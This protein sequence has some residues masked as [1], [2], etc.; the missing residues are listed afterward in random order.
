MKVLVIEP[1]FVHFGG[2][3]RSRPMCA[4]LSRKNIK[5]DLLVSSNSNFR[6]LIRRKKINENFRQYELPRINIHP[7]L[8]GRIL[9]GMIALWFGIFGRYDIIFARVPTQLESNIPAFFLRLLGKKVVLDWDDYWMGSPIFNGHNLIKK[10]IRF[11][12]TKS[13]KFF[14][15]MVVISDFLENKAKELGA[16]KIL[17]LINGVVVD[18]FKQRDPAESFEKL[19]LDKSKKYLLS[20]G[21][22]YSR[23]RTSLLFKAFEKMLRLDKE[24]RL[25]CNFDLAKKI[26]EQNLERK[27][28]EECLEN[29]IGM[30]YLSHKDL[31]YCL[32]IA[33][34][35][36]FLQGE[37][38]DELA[39]YP[40][41]IGSYL[42][43]GVVIVMND[44]D[45]EAG[46]TMKKY[47]CAIIEK[48][49]SILA[50]KTVDFLNNEE[51]Q[52]EMK[53]RTLLAKR[54]LSWDNLI[55][56]LI[57]FFESIK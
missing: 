31:E 43:G 52:R 56:K 20:I 23:D 14:G 54:D 22:T 9:R 10:Y 26:R 30:G 6:L 44:T 39:C 19:K 1:C 17:K 7:F 38:E 35:A 2:H 42:D 25:I 41:R 37:T 32:S 24:I 45:S 36:I 53:K 29:T 5:V 18:E 8:N 47:R 3:N 55:V 13:P 48:D 34:A 40:V 28:S 21:N 11:C 12:E 27:I 49:L 33:S 50:E 16:K 51:S 15:N 4:S 57:S 46:N